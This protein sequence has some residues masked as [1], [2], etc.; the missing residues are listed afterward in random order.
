MH[1]FENEETDKVGG[2]LTISSHIQFFTAMPRHE[3]LFFVE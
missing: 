2:S 3:T 1:I